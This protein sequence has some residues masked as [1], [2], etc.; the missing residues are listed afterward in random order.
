MV[1]SFMMKNKGAKEGRVCEWMWGSLISKWLVREVLI[2]TVTFEQRPEVGAK[3]IWTS[4]RR[5]T[6]KGATCAKALRWEQLHT[7]ILGATEKPMRQEPA[8][9]EESS[10]R[11]WGQ[12]GDEGPDH[13][14]LGFYS[15][16]MQ[17]QWR[18][19]AEKWHNLTYILTG[20]SEL[21]FWE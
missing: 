10:R 9:E 15:E 12:G 11:R 5:K 16:A 17:S 8:S 20:F 14:G 3:D 19:W 18:V 2:K 1:V 4:R 13:V 7:F 21:L 6:Q